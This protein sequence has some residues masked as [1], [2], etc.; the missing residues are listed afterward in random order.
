VGSDIK[1]TRK[2]LFLEKYVPD[3]QPTPG[4]R[5]LV[6][7]AQAAGLKTVVASSATS[8]ELGALLKAAGVA[9]VL[10]EA[11]TAD[12]AEHSKPDPDI[13]ETALETIGLPASEVVMIGDTPYDI[14]AADKAG[15]RCI[16]VRCGGWDGVS[17]G[18]AAAIYD[19]PADILAHRDNITF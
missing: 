4:S 10:T 15:V 5:D 1:E 13:V 12:D 14:E 18:G 17:L 7:A 11:T 19:D 8:D 16:A 2:K 3:L 9:D 6:L